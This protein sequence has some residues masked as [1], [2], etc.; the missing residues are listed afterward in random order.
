MNDKYDQALVILILAAVTAQHPSL[1]ISRTYLPYSHTF[2]KRSSLAP[3]PVAGLLPLVAV[4]VFVVGALLVQPP[5]S[6]SAATLGVTAENPPEAP[7]IIG[8]F[9]KE[10]APELPHP[11]SL[12][13]AGAGVG[14]G[15]A[16]AGGCCL[17]ASGVDHALPHTS[18]PD[19][20][21]DPKVPK[22]PSGFEAVVGAAG[23]AAGLE[24]LKTEDDDVVDVV[25]IADWA[26]GAAGAGAGE[27]KSNKSPKDAEAGAGA[28]FGAVGWDASGED[29]PPNPKELPIDCFGW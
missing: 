9:A 25:V 20:L 3:N 6:S 29:I 18:A 8:V 13:G 4:V 7:G 14:A 10:P 28:G 15:F 22:V 16:A 19:K 21:L 1:S 5:N 17:G 24:R 11:K 27:E 26:A 12:T 2:E 23:G